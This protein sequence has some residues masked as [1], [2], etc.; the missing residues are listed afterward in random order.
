MLF[1]DRIRNLVTHYPKLSSAWIKTGDSNAPLKRV[2]MN[3][4]AL[5]DSPVE[6][7]GIAITGDTAELTED[8][9]CW[10]A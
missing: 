1:Q 7:A 9:L 2:W 6:V 5:R 3:E 8:H 10:A 4:S